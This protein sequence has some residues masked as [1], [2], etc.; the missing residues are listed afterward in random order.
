[1]LSTFRNEFG[2]KITIEPLSCSNLNL[3]EFDLRYKFREEYN[4][5]DDLA[6]H[7]KHKS[8]KVQE[9]YQKF[10]D[11]QHQTDIIWSEI[12]NNTSK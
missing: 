1:M 10:I 9:A 7:I 8:N 2:R 11:C 5:L 3:L 6:R 12:I 4:A